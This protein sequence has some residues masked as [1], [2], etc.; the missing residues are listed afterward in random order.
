MAGKTVTGCSTIPTFTTNSANELRGVVVSSR[1]IPVMPQEVIRYLVSGKDGIYLDCTVGMGG[2]AADILEAT[3]P[4]GCLIGIDTDLKAVQFSRDYLSSY[5]E[6]VC[7]IH[8]NFADLSEILIQ[9]NITEV[10]G[11]LMDLGVSSFQLDTPERGFSFSKSGPL[12]MRMDQTKGNPVSDDLN[13]KDVKELEDI[14][15]SYGEERWAR[16]IARKIVEVREESPFVSTTQLAELVEKS[17]PRGRGR[18]HPATRTF[19]AFRIYKNK[20]LEN[21]KKGLESA[22]AALKSG[23]KICV[24]TFHSLEDRIVKH[25]FKEME[26]DCIC[27]P[28][29]PICICKHKPTLKILTKRPL[30][31]SQDEVRDN[32]RSRSAKLRAAMKL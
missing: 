29:T 17:I 12:D 15:R 19:Q 27:P 5:G 10:N 30:T 16:R 24:I 32:P 21:L 31:A 6:R 1:H 7:I 8:G 26:K 4:D 22:V 20:E 13:S 11:I 3:Y 25:T 2:H 9:Q 23:G 28:K 18:I 14:I